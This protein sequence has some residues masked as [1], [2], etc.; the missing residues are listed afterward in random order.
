VD[1]SK[2]FDTIHHEK[3]LRLVSPLCDQAT[4]ELIGKLLSVGY[5]DI[6]NLSNSVL[7]NDLG[8][9]QGSL[10]SPMLANLYL[11]E[12]DRF[13]DTNLIPKWNRGDERRFVEGYQTRKVLTSGQKQLLDQLGI[14]GIHEVVQAYKHTKWVN[15]GG[16]SR[17]PKDPNFNR[18][19]YVRYA[20]DFL[21]GFTGTRDDA[22]SIMNE[23]TE[24]LDR[25]LKLK[26]NENK[27]GIHH[28]SDKNIKFLG[29]L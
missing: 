21:F 17:D 2:Y 14:E 12:L 13:V 9:P 28:S 1:V 25:E 10:I 23:V 27:S 4:K 20:D 19:H 22:K 29:F 5:V 16:T 8:T 6:S 11:H 18:L 24:F 3:L 26:V 7:R 15:D